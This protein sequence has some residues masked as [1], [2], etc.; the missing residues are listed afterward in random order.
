MHLLQSD[1]R[2]F[3]LLVSIAAYANGFSAIGEME[4]RAP[5]LTGASSSSYL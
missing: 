3:V 1:L 4:I 5:H 2:I